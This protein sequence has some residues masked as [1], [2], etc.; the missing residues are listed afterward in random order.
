[1]VSADASVVWVVSV[2]V[3]GVSVEVD[4][5][6]VVCSAD[7]CVV[8]RVVTVVSEVDPSLAVDSVDVENVDTVSA[9]VVSWDCGELATEAVVAWCVLDAL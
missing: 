1:M 2:S 9:T 5:S 8:F 7:V 3:P 6:V 4:E